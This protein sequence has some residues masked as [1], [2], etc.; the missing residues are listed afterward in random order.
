MKSFF[1]SSEYG[2]VGLLFFFIFFCGV[3]I[4]VFRPNSKK[5]YDDQASIP[6]KEND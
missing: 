1:A 2:M 4:W 3:L 5:H 6:L